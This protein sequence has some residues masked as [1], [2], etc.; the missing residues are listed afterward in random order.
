MKKIKKIS[1]RD[2]LKKSV[3]A[4]AIGSQMFINTKCARSEDT[5]RIG[6]IPITDATPL[7]IA[8]ANNYFKDEGL[9]AAEPVLIRSWSALIEAFLADRVNLV[10]FLMPIPIWMRYNNNTGVKIVAWDHTNGS[11]L[12]VRGD[13][14]IKSF[15]DLGGKQIAVPFWYSM[16]NVI[17]Q[18]GLKKFGLKP[19]IRPQSEKLKSSEVNLFILPPPDMPLSLAAKK[20]DGYIVAEPF[21]A[22]GELKIKA[23]ILRFTGD[24]WKNHPCCT[25]V[26]KENLINSKMAF[27]QKIVNAIVRAEA[28]I[29]D[30]RVKTAKILSRDGRGYLPVDEKVTLKVF[31]DYDIKEYGDG[32]IPQAIRHP[33]WHID[34]IGFQPYPY[35]SA[36]KFM[37]ES[38]KNTLVE[39]DNNFLKKYDANF[40]AD[41]VI[42][43]RFVK[44]AIEYAGGI[45]KFPSMDLASPW[46]REEVIDI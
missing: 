32:N 37:F 29:L 30:N 8:H 1:R 36:T 2:F 12:T 11:A 6:Y 24:M 13:G 18:L 26:M 44:K 19:V 21:N 7:L 4:A 43:Y 46:E 15:A 31:T 23:K 16:H 28:W 22:L 39:G 40:V 17:L 41:D 42:D 5:V 20:I 35:P 14:S 3:V 33:E 27:T 38:L 9:K 45:K 10:H 25:V 34:R